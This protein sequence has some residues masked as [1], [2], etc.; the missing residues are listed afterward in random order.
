MSLEV[1][2]S[3]MFTKAIVFFV[4][5]IAVLSLSACDDSGECPCPSGKTDPPIDDLSVTWERGNIFANLM[6]IVP[7][8]PIVCRVWLILENKNQWKAFSRVDV[9]M[10][11]VISLK[12]D[13]TLG[14]IPIETD[15]DNILAPGTK[16][17][18]FFYKNTGDNPIFGP[19]CGDFVL[20]DFVIENADGDTKVF[21]SDT[22]TFECAF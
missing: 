15:W 5:L 6:P 17:T 21:R 1:K 2:G 20:L 19:P 18:V 4:A 3:R 9:P 16:D 13:S 7:P 14:I 11:D 12:N 10:A 22:L 8:D